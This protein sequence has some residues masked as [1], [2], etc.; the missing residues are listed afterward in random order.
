MSFEARYR[1][2][3]DPWHTLASEYEHDKRERTLAACGPGPFGAAVDLGAGLGLLSEAL[4]PRCERLIAI[5]GASTAARAARS[6]LRAFPQ[7]EVVAGAIPDVLPEGSFDLVVASEILYYLDERAL[8]ATL[9]WT[10]RHLA[11][12]GRV[13]AVHWS[14]SAHDLVRSAD[15]ISA[16]LAATP[17]LRVVETE[18]DAGYRLDVLERSE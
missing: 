6:R 8:A 12:G 9:R 10:A 2:T 1:E 3:A 18:H 15:A 17:G 14:G 13:V 5:E 16:R 4:A 7:A 11:P